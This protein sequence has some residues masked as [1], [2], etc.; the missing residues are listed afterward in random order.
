MVKDKDK[1]KDKAKDREIIY[2]RTHMD[3]YKIMINKVMD[4]TNK[5]NMDRGIIKI[6]KANIHQICIIRKKKLTCLWDKLQLV[7]FM[8][9]K[10]GSIKVIFRIKYFKGEISNG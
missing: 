5:I 6:S 8:I 10:I 9:H 2:N 1:I 7:T 3:K 4:K